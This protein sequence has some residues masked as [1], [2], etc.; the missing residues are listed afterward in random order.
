MKEREIYNGIRAL[1]PV[2]IRLD[3]RAF[4]KFL[5]NQSLKK[6]FDKEFADAMV[7]VCS[8]FFTTSGFSPL[9][10]YTFSDEISLYLRELPFE[11][12][13]EKMASVIASFASSA[14]TITMNLSTPIA[15]DARIIPIEPGLVSEYLSW[16]QKEAWRNHM[17][18]YSQALLIQ[19]GL[20]PEVAQRRLD[21]VSAG[22]LHELCFQHGINLAFTPAWERR[23]IMV[24]KKKTEKEGVNPITGEKTRAIRNVV[25][26][27]RD[28]PLFSKPEGTDLLDS[29]LNCRV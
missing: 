14:L 13:V 19:D 8:A 25:I 17:N 28:L 22:K 5:A 21:G 27:D 18:G 6:P 4:H 23:G 26:E 7:S 10:A 9:L 15:F 11:G 1:P 12:R 20:R 24:Y 16:R 2:I 3:G 29:I